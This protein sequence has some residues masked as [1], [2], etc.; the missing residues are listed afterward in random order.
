MPDKIRTRIDKF[1]TCLKTGGTLRRDGRM[2]SG[3]AIPPHLME[4][5]DLK[6]QEEEVMPYPMNYPA[7]QSGDY[8]PEQIY[9]QAHITQGKNPDDEF[10]GP[11]KKR[12]CRDVICLGLFLAFLALMAAIAGYSLWTGSYNRL[13]EGNFNLCD[14]ADDE[15]P[16]SFARVKFYYAGKLDPGYFNE[17]KWDP[18]NFFD[19]VAAA[20]EE[21]WPYVIY[22][23]LIALGISILMTA[24]L[25]VFAG[26]MIWGV[27][28]IFIVLSVGGTI[29]L[30]VLW[31]T[32]KNDKEADGHFAQNRKT[33]ML[34][35]AIIISIIAV[36]FLLVLLILRKRIAL[37][38][39]LFR[40]AGKAVHAVP[41]VFLQPIYTFLFQGIVAAIFVSLSVLIETSRVKR[42]DGTCKKPAFATYSR[43]LNIFGYYWMTQFIIGCQHVVVA[44]AIARWFFTRDKSHLG[45]PLLTSAKN[46][47]RYHLGSVAFGS[48]IIAIV[49][50]IRWCMNQLQKY[51]S[52]VNSCL[53]CLACLCKCC[54]WCLDGFLQ[55]LNRNAY[56]EIAIYGYAFCPSAKRAF[57]VISTNA[58]RILA[59]NSIGDFVL[60]LAKLTIV[61][62]SALCGYYLF[63][64]TIPAEETL[65]IEWA[66]IVIGI[67]F[68]YVIAHCFISTYEMAIDTIFVCFCEDLEMND[69]VNRPYFMSKGLMKFVKENNKGGKKE[70]KQKRER[71]SSY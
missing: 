65:D 33:Y 27:V 39:R 31:G 7:R 63:Q 51:L 43:Y 53:A 57:K 29:A 21:Y 34:V 17:T 54:L 42:D 20:F 9:G 36:I 41:F 24:C 1:Q 5:L 68:S 25:R 69:G 49:K 37:V 56:I 19:D 23:C 61:A 40:E 48:L 35:F 60:Y 26:V 44:G 12:K 4:L 50:F 38:V 11:L 59:I 71:K 15:F 32:S 66:L 22:M 45:F 47:L 28:G 70:K 2:P 8:P 46:L 30:W 3:P 16:T 6:A 52:N 13:K 58:L 67:V 18:G 64:G 62:L 14:K 55:F 10:E